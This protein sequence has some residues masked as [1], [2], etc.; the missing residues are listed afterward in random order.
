[1]KEKQHCEW[2]NREITANQE[3]VN[4]GNEETGIQH[5]HEI[6]YERALDKLGQ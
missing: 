1:M 5:Y 6:C 4:S 2:C 3:A